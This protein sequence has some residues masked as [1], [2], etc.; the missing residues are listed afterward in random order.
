M[1]SVLGITKG[2]TIQV[3]L[4]VVAG[5]RATVRSGSTWSDVLSKMDTLWGGAMAHHIDFGGQLA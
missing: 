5:V 1:P 2:L 4:C 3:F